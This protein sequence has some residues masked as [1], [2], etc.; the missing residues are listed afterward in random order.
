MTTFGDLIAESRH[1]LTTARPDRINVLDMTVDD[2]T[3]QI[4]LRYQTDGIDAGTTLC[5]DL[6]EMHVISVSG[7]AAGSV[8]TVIREFNGSIAV[9]HAAGTPIRVSPHFSDFRIGKY[10]NRGLED[11]SI[12]LF[13]IKPL[14]FDFNPSVFSYELTPADLI[15][16]WRVTYD[17]PGPNKV[18]TVMNPSEWYVDLSANTTDFPSG[19]SITLRYPGSAGF[20]VRIAYRAGFTPLTDIDDNVLTVSGLHTEAHDLPPL[21]AGWMLASGREIKRS[22]TTQQ[23]ERRRQ[24]EVPPGAARMGADELAKLYNQRIVREAARLKRRYPGAI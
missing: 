13:Q 8:A 2:T 15:D 5:M 17:S 11:L 16:V 6:E 12:D 9:Q 4:K 3:D 10:I 19:K 23:P 24:E 20:P 1:H 18:W 7:V 21:Y 14:E 22:F